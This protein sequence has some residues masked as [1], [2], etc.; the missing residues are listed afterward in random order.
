MGNLEKPRHGW[1]GFS[2]GGEIYGSQ[3]KATHDQQKTNI[4]L[5]MFND[6]IN[7]GMDRVM[8]YQIAYG[9]SNEEAKELASRD[10]YNNLISCGVP[11]EM[12]MEI[13][14][15]SNDDNQKTR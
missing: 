1:E 13:A 14:Y 11:Q 12:A 4:K 7:K 10:S 5:E 2:N 9:I 8:A 6:M 15:G 3:S